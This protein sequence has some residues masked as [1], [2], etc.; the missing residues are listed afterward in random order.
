M[1]A[2]K[3][4]GRSFIAFIFWFIFNVRREIRNQRIIPQ[5]FAHILIYARL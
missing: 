1:K 4:L 2:M 5:I 3:L